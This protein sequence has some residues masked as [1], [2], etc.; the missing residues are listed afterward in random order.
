MS[1]TQEDLLAWT[2][3][4]FEEV[5]EEG[6]LSLVGAVRYSASGGE[7]PLMSLTSKMDAAKWNAD[8]VA[9]TL[10]SICDRDARPARR[11][12]VPAGSLRYGANPKPVRFIPFQ[13]GSVER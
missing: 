9:A 6:G 5:L 2:R 3:E 13:R 10:G 1:V 11:H 4:R 8:N 7:L 12:P